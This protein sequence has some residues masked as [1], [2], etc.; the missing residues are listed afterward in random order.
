MALAES[1]A[2]GG[3][4]NRSPISRRL[5]RGGIH[6]VLG[7]S[8]VVQFYSK[9]RAQGVEPY[10]AVAVLEHRRNYLAE[11]GEPLVEALEPVQVWHSY[12]GTRAGAYRHRTQR[13]GR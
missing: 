12:R 2:P 9:S 11:G 7:R 3:R 10:C 8:L 1:P 4:Y 5:I 13:V 6:P